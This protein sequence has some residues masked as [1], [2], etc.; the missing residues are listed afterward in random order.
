MVPPR[1]A[2]VLLALFALAGPARAEEASGCL[3]GAKPGW[4][5]PESWVWGQI[6]AG[7]PADLMYALI[8]LT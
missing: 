4:S 1:I 2:L 7:K 5:P 3:A 8:V 6:C